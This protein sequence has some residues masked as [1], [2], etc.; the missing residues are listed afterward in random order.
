MRGVNTLIRDCLF[1]NLIES[2]RGVVFFKHVSSAF[3]SSYSFIGFRVG[4]CKTNCF[5]G[6]DKRF[7]STETQPRRSLKAVPELL[8]RVPD[9]V[10]ADTL[11]AGIAWIALKTTNLISRSSRTTNCRI[12]RP[13][14]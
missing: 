10:N 14:P 7:F 3:P 8:N 5:Y 6:F 11:V 4:R 2:D 12:A 13:V 1:R 9:W